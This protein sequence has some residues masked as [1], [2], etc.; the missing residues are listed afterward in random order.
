MANAF[1][2]MLFRMKYIRRWG[3]MHSVVS[4]NLSTHSMEVSVIAHALALIGN[5]YFGRSYD[6]DRITTKALYHD[7]PEI[8]TGDIPTPV[9]YFNKDTKAAYDRVEKAALNKF[10]SSLPDELKENYK[11]LFDY[12]SDDMKIIK[13]ADKIC[14]FLKC[15]E[16]ERSGNKEF[17]AAKESLIKSISTLRCEEADYF[18]E[19]FSSG[20]D[21][22][23]DTLL[24]DE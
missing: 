5:T 6:C 16:E 18:L 17:S 24:E 14:A 10:L 22:P 2:A 4:E 8:L 7:L 13:A 23:I 1:F 12:T 15:S 3:I 21:L 9:K 20:F 11:K 19:N